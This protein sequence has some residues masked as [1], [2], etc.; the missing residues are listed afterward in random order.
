MLFC[1]DFDQT[2]VKGHFHNILM[3]ARCIPA[4]SSTH[5]PQKNIDT[6]ESLL[7]NPNSGLKNPEEM[8]D[9]IR[10][11]LNNG[12]QI[13]ITSFGGYPEVFNPTL[14][15][16][17]LSDEEIQQIARIPL[18]L[19]R[20]ETLTPKHKIDQMHQ[21]MSRLN[22]TDRNQVLLID[23]SQANCQEA[24]RNGFNSIEVPIDINATPE[25]LV[26][27]HVLAAQP[28]RRAEASAAIAPEASARAA[29]ARDPILPT[30]AT[31]KSTIVNYING[32]TVD[33]TEAMMRMQKSAGQDKAREFKQKICQSLAIDGLF[34]SAFTNAEEL[35]RIP[36]YL[37]GKTNVKLIK[38]MTSEQQEKYN[39]IINKT[40]EQYPRL[41]SVAYGRVCTVGIPKGPQPDPRGN[42]R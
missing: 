5:I 40:T 7:N 32:D 42:G 28:A 20:G 41:P 2:I 37:P 23:D 17:G 15:R 31:S 21:A 35:R 27:A 14:K 18:R 38:T 24:I 22:I 11:A 8:R 1:I 10:E 13:A 19:S 3:N 6:I 25:Y 36:E 33:L 26:Q 16:M 34:P 9:F 39:D 4:G 30:P 12:H 29:A